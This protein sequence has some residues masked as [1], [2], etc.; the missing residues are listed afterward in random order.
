MCFMLH[1]C[2]LFQLSCTIAQFYGS[3]LQIWG[4]KQKL[5]LSLLSLLVSI[6][7]YS[8]ENR[9]FNKANYVNFH[10]N[11]CWPLSRGAMA[12]GDPWKQ[13]SPTCIAVAD[14]WTAESEFWSLLVVIMSE[15]MRHQLE[16][17]R[18]EIL[19]VY[20]YHIYIYL[21]IYICVCVCVC[22]MFW[23]V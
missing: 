20:V 16:C 13:Q 14:M 9:C 23:L 7:H 19:C 12:L 22:F 17:T 1:I 2:F 3:Y 6:S 5:S 8:N 10:K 11:N 4:V 18:T 15:M 21:Y